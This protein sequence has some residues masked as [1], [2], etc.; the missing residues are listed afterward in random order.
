MSHHI[1]N[2][3]VSCPCPC[4][5]LNL[6]TLPLPQKL[7][8]RRMESGGDEA[9]SDGDEAWSWSDGDEAMSDGDET[10]SVHTNPTLIFPYFGAL[11][12]YN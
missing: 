7:L 1:T 10:V 4:F 8:Q 12:S 11:I 9:W 5:T 6:L 3:D 2:V